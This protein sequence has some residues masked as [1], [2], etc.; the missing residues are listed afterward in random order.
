MRIRL[1][2]CGSV[3]VPI[4]LTGCGG[5]GEGVAPPPSPAAIVVSSGNGQTG[6]AGAALPGPLRVR[7]TSASGAGLENIAVTFSVAANSGIVSPATALTDADGLAGTTWTLGTAVGANLDTVRASVSGVGTPAVFAASVVAA[8]VASLTAASGNAQTG[9]AGRPL[10]LP[11]VVVARD[12]FGNPKDHVDVSWTVVSGGG[13]LSNLTGTT[14]ADGQTVAFWTLGSGGTHTVEAAASGLADSPVTF[15]ATL[16]AAES[17]LG[18]DAGN[19]QTGAPGQLLAVPLVVSLKTQAGTAVVGIPVVWAVTVGGGTLSQTTAS[20]DGQGRSSATWTLGQATGA[21]TATVTVQGATGSPATFGATATPPSG[22]VTLTAVS[23]A[24][25]VE[26]QGATLT[27]NG[28]STTPGNNDVTVGGLPATVTAASSTSL[29]VSVPVFDC[30]PARGVPIQVRVGGEASNVLTQAL[31]PSSFTTVAVGQQLVLQNPADFCLQFPASA[32]AEDYLIG[33]QSTSEVVTSLTPA[34]LTAVAAGPQTAPPLPMI[35]SRSGSTVRIN[36]TDRAAERWAKHYAAEARLRRMELRQF[37]PQL[38]ESVRLPHAGTAQALLSIPENVGVGDI[39]PIRVPDIVGGDL[40]NFTPINAVVRVVGAKGIWLEDLDNP[41]G[42]YTSAEFQALSDKLDNPIYDTDVGYFGAPS[43]FDQ[44]NHIVVVITKEVNK[45]EGVGG[46][47]TLV[48]FI[49]RSQCAASNEGEIFYGIAPLASNKA[50]TLKDFP[51]L[52]AHEFSHIIQYS[53]RILLDA[54]FMAG[55]TAEGQATLAEEIVG[56]AVEG[57]S[58]GQ[59]YGFDVAFNQD[60]QTSQDWYRNRF[61]YLAFYFGFAGTTK[62]ANAPEQCSWLGGPPEHSG[63]CGLEDFQYYGV[64]WSLL[65]WLSD[66]YGPGFPGGE[67]GLQRALV[68]NQA[69]GY[70]NIANVIPAP[71]K[72]LLAQWAATLYTDDRVTGLDARLTLPSWNLFD[73]MIRSRRR[74]GCSPAPGC[75]RASRTRSAC[76]QGRAPTSE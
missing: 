36:P 8:S 65:R 68:D 3:A 2:A 19:N 67:R 74:G 56:H 39:V 47:V 64:S 16:T 37:G 14:G 60:D 45:K 29:S 76:G 27:G 33:V 71:F 66:Q 46:F 22:V 21:Q 69:M 12:R 48:D 35:A 7:V 61:F 41:Q 11:L 49:L 63:P 18:I 1:W 15:T 30:Q 20:T 73:P 34:L 31:N 55:W 32:S 26:G 51:R 70:D 42:G 38:A 58:P 43:D 75:F 5:G 4:A 25:I 10:S 9:A 44:N 6:P 24:T 28:F 72:T 23:P 53:R 13:T 52:I 62:V 54:P 59:N 50:A 17:Q 40:C 57:R